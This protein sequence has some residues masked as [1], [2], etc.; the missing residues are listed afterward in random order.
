MPRTTPATPEEPDD[1][2]EPDKRRRPNGDGGLHWDKS[3]RRWIASVTVGYTPAGKRIV[4]TAS[5]RSKSRALKKLQQKLRDRE[6][7]LPSEDTRYTVR[8][9]VEDWFE[10]GLAGRAP[11]TVETWE[12]LAKNHIIP[13]LGARKLRELTADDVDRW[14]ASK[15]KTL[16]T[17]T[18]RELVSILKRAVARAQAR[19]RVRRNVVLLCEVPKGQPGRPSKSLTF[20]QAVAFLEAAAASGRPDMHAYVTVSMLTGIRT[21]EARALRWS[22]VVGYD[23]ERQAWLPVDKAGWNHQ[24]FAVYVWRADRHGE[25]TKT[26]KSRRSLKLPARCIS[27]LHELYSAQGG[28]FL[29]ARAAF[30]PDPDRLVFPKPDGG[31]QGPMDILR[32]FRKVADRAGLKGSEWTT[33]ELRHTFVSLLSDNEMPIEDIARLVGHSSTRVT[34]TVYRHQLRPVMESGATQMDRLF[35]GEPS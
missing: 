11:K 15:A 9:A 1:D 17:K 34:E 10:F 29:D 4:R 25:D 28:A 33:R 13:D 14:L 16:S 18:L 3:R 8:Q 20:D 26:E 2:N 35:P 31:K 22:H 23:A 30:P 7:G 5:D 32:A 19:E 21:E 27:A 12:G 24:E 6:D